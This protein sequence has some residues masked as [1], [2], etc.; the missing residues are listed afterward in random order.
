MAKV[1]WMFPQ[2]TLEEAI[3]IAKA[4]EDKN[5]GKPMK[6]DLLVKAIGFNKPNDWR[7]KNLLKSANLYELVSWERR[8]G[9]CCARED[10]PGCCCSWFATGT[11]KSPIGGFPTRGR[12]RK[13]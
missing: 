7:F 12:F 5:A 13:G 8:K 4:I 2:N 6:A 9:D 1:P 10:R 11:Q 3:S